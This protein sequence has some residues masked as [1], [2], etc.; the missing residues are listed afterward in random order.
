MARVVL[1]NEVTGIVN[2]YLKTANT[3]DYENRTDAL[4][5]PPALL[6][7]PL[8]GDNGNPIVPIKY[9]IV[10]LPGKVL[11]EMDVA[12]KEVVVLEESAVAAG[13]QARADAGKGRETLAE[14]NAEMVRLGL[15]E[16]VKAD[17]IGSIHDVVILLMSGQLVRAKSVAA[18][19]VPAGNLTQNM[20]NKLNV[21]LEREL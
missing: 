7:V 16:S 8:I 14:L 21:F 1:F 3:P 17:L 20:I 19:L 2:R 11:R 15:N 5:N 6:T 9:W 18:A 4:I 12:E 13:D 10:D